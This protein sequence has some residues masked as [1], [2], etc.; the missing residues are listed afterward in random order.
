LLRRPNYG[1]IS[2]AAADFP[3]VVL[4]ARW[5]KRRMRGPLVERNAKKAAFLREATARLQL[6]RTVHLTDNRG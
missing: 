6:A 5:R 2:A 1:L 3:A 4:A